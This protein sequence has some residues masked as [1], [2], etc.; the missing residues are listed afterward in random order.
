MSCCR[1]IAQVQTKT[2]ADHPMPIALTKLKWALRMQIK[3]T[4][5]LR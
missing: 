4:W 1:V 2:G 5:A 3:L